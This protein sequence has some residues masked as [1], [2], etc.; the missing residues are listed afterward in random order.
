MTRL[1]R[2]TA[3]DKLEGIEA[4]LV[5]GASYSWIQTQEAF[6]ELIAKALRVR[7]IALD[8]EFHRERTYWPKVALIQ[9]RVADEIFPVD[10]LQV[11]CGPFAEVL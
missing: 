4:G 10:P 7:R 2:L 3:N 9:V 1:R 6:S 8:T 5:A 11:D